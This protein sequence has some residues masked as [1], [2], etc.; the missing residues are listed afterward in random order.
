VHTN[1]HAG[2]AD[3]LTKTAGIRDIVKRIVQGKPIPK[4][5]FFEKRRVAK[6]LGVKP[7]AVA[8]TLAERQGKDRLTKALI[9]GGG[10]TAGSIAGGA[11]DKQANGDM[12]AYLRDTSK[13]QQARDKKR[14]M[15]KQAENMTGAGAGSYAPPPAPS[16]ERMQQHRDELLRNRKPFKPAAAPTA[17]APSMERM[18]QHRDE[19]LRNRK[20]F[21]P[22]T[23]TPG[24]LVAKR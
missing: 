20:P 12:I 1:F 16:M 10:L 9:A 5:G 15:A 23:P 22:A 3:E 21:K 2:F 8:A 24:Q 17:Q 4:M 19:L 14:R 18:Q 13:A 11:L 6:A 7:S